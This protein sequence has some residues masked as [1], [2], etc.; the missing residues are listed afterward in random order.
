MTIV[1]CRE[2]SGLGWHH[3]NRYIGNFIDCLRTKQQPNLNAEAGYHVMLTIALGIKAYHDNRVCMFDPAR[4]E[5][6]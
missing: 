4:Q 1:F 3:F 2:H 5:L 6:I